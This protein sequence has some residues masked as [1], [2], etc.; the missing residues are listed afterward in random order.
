MATRLIGLGVAAVLGIAAMLLP[1][2]DWWLI[3][4]G[5]V[6]IAGGLA[7]AVGL[8]VAGFVVAPRLQSDSARLGRAAVTFSAIAFVA[9]LPLLAVD[10]AVLSARPFD[11][12]WPVASGPVLGTLLGTAVYAPEVLVVAVVA[13]AVWTA[14]TSSALKVLGPRRRVTFGDA[15]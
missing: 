12:P 8:A 15:D 3:D 13:G 14:A 9:A 6:P 10:A 11:E 2:A 4:N 7:A 5:F 1:L